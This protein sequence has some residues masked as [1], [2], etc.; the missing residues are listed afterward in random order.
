MG[1]FDLKLYDT[2]LKLIEQY[3]RNT[4][5]NT[6]K[7]MIQIKSDKLVLATNSDLEVY[8]IISLTSINTLA[9]ENL[10]INKNVEKNNST[11]KELKKYLNAHKDSILTLTKLSGNKEDLHVY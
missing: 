9:K 10:S 3:S 1:G 8:G 6:I 2:D 7:Y 11:I 5:E 4:K